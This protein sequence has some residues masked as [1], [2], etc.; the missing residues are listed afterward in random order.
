VGWTLL[1]CTVTFVARRYSAADIGGVWRGNQR[2]DDK[3]VKEDG[4]LLQE[5][6]DLTEEDGCLPQEDDD[7]VKEDS[8][9]LREDGE[10]AKEDD[11]FLKEDDDCVC[12][13]LHLPVSNAG[14]CAGGSRKT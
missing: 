5:D 8:N 11:D 3:I 10:I 7:P 6:D 9:L 2:K 13:C 4:D 1:A 14:R 12:L